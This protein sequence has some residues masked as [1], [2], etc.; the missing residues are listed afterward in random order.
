MDLA[1]FHLRLPQI[2]PAVLAGEDDPDVRTAAAHAA[3]GCSL[4]ARAL[5]NAR[6]L[7]TARPLAVPPPAAAPAA[8]LRDRVLGST[9]ALATAAAPTLG[10]RLPVRFFDPSAEVARL[11]AGAEGEAER[12]AEVDA[13][14]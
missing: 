13:L 3:T 9:R 8:A 4:C 12:T 11:H 7:G 1:A 6:D 10:S 5:V 2:A 14:A